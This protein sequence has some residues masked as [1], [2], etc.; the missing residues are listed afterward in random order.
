MTDL[1]KA[2][3]GLPRKKPSQVN[4]GIAKPNF[5]PLKWQYYF[6]KED[7]I[8]TESGK[9]HVYIKG[10]SGPLVLCLHGGGYNGLTWSLFAKE[11]HENI[12][13]QVIAIDFRGHG[14]TKTNDDN[15]LS[16]ETLSE[17]V[18]EIANKLAERENAKV[19]LVGHSMGGAIAVSASYKIQLLVGLCV[20]DV[21][22]GTALD[23]LSSMQSIL[24]GRPTS[25]KSIPHA[26]RWCYKG[27]QCHNLEAARISMPGQII[28]AKTGQLACDEWQ[29]FDKID[30]INL[31]N[32]IEKQLTV[33]E[34]SIKE[35]D[36][37]TVSEQE[38]TKLGPS[39]SSV[40]ENAFKRPKTTESQSNEDPY[41]WRIDLSQTE[42]YWQQWFQGL[43]EKF[44]G[45][46]CPKIL[47]LANIFGLDT[48]LT[49]GQM[50][51]KF[52]L[53]VLAKTGHAVHEDQPRQ[54]AELLS[55]YL[56]KQK[57]A[58]TKPGFSMPLYPNTCC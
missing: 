37:E 26:I 2:V 13:C 53:Q 58:E 9:H 25:F 35:I 33:S 15:D 50:Q 32:P 52:Q 23:A 19:I 27:G 48:K 21:V 40:N 44:L 22:E 57:C 56:V 34:S 31:S 5:S 8:E 20:I 14:N 49:V 28:N 7:Y 4:L 36:E 16:L 29:D 11:I 39:A 42:T 51:G 45:T 43:S 38:E 12:E 55:I 47:I 17:D 18:A 6:D 41:L 54:V 1:R 46:S 30:G 10:S 24:R 3:L